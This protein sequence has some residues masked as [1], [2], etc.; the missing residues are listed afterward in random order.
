MSNKNFYELSTLNKN[1]LT[2]MIEALKIEL[3]ENMKKC[4]DI[5]KVFITHKHITLFIIIFNSR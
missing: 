2:C 1:K 3:L 5:L 4:E